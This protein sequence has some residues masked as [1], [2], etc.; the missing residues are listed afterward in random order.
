MSKALEGKVALVTGGA[1]GIGAGIVTTLANAGAQVMIA[2]IG[3]GSSTGAD[4]ENWRYNLAS[5]SDL[6]ATLAQAKGL[7]ATHVDVTDRASCQNAVATTLA[8]FGRLDI[9]VNNAGIVDSGPVGVRVSATDCFK[10]A[11]RFVSFRNAASSDSTSPIAARTARSYPKSA[12]CC[13]A[14]A[15]SNNA[16]LRPPE[17]RDH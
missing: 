11:C 4:D 13:R 10:S 1:R 2:D 12:C 14:L 17:N 16:R 7:Q 8:T 3:V 6:S 5:E 15:P 9:L